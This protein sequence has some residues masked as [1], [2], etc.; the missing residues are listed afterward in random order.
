M[1]Y[2]S[3]RL[4]PNA[5]AAALL[6]EA[7]ALDARGRA[8]EAITVYQRILERWP[9]AAECWYNLA[10]LQRKTRQYAAALA[11]YQRALDTGVERPEEVHLNRG[12]I[13]ADC[14]R[15]DAAAERELAAAL[16]RNPS[17]VPALFNLANLQE[18][19]GRRDAARA[20]YERILALD[21]NAHE[22]LARYAYL[23]AFVRADDPLI[24]RLRRALA[25]CQGASERASL[26]FA[27]GRALDACQEY[28]AAFQAYAQ[29]NRASRDSVAAGSAHYDRGRA[30]AL[31]DALIGAFPKAGAATE[32][33]R[34]STAGTRGPQPIFVCGMFRSGSTL[35]EQLLAGHPR[36]VA[37]GELDF[38]PHAVQ[39]RLAPY[40]AALAAAAAGT[41]KAL[42]G[43]YREMLAA[44]FPGAEFV[45]DKRPD[46]FLHIGLIKRL[47]PDAKIL[48]TTRAPLDNC[49]SIYFLHLDPAL[50]YALDLL[51]IGHHYRQYLRLMAH[52]KALFGPDILDVD[53]DVLVRD[54]RP[55]AARMLG[56]LGLDWDDRCLSVP[57][58]GRSVK[59][60]SV[61]QVREP[62][63]Q[64]SSGRSRHYARELAPLRSYLES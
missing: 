28:A 2:E 27:L 12:V 24:A 25:A 30:E 15:D 13:Y 61:W 64:R 46:N 38:L 55:V 26:G 7:L 63:Y 11:S 8:A 52:W 33:L 40:P 1:A 32:R 51:D 16:A 50:S 19:L 60:A 41:L 47:F 59:T 45:T 10:V 6:R 42:A 22:A 53:Y 18:D 36:V 14:L 44:R 62:L 35:T 9:G 31:V 4:S 29:A 5:D 49:L 20:S 23:H 48:H 17:Y 3:C 54:V 56:F 37:G 39:T 43:E 58:A 21:P 34:T 57:P